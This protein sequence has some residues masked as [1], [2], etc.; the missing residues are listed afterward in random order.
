MGKVELKGT[1]AFQMFGDLYRI[2]QEFWEYEEDEDYWNR[3][4]DATCWFLDRNKSEPYAE[5]LIL[6]FIEWKEE[7]HKKV[8]TQKIM[9]GEKV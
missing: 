5:R 3:L 8:I 9:R 2:A 7:E 4:Y 6:S 1:K